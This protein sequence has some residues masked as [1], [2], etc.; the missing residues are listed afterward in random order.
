MR[1]RD[2]LGRL[3]AVLAGV[4]ASVGITARGDIV[5][6][7]E[8]FKVDGWERREKKPE[9][10]AKDRVRIL[11]IHNHAFFD[12]NLI[13]VDYEVIRPDGDKELRSIVAKPGPFEL[14]L[15]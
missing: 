14:D 15:S 9:P 12:T 11:V 2:L 7:L 13:V 1:R 5:E 6:G 8:G 10:V 3:G 4:A